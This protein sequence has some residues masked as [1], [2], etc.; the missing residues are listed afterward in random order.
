MNFNLGEGLFYYLLNTDIGMA[1]T[2]KYAVLAICFTLASI[3]VGYLLGSVNS[4]IVVSKLLYREDIRSHG[5][6]NAGLTNMLR[7]Y[8]K[9]AAGLT[10]LGD[11]LKTAIAVF[12]GGVLGGFWYIGGISLSGV[13][14]QLPLTYIAGFF[15]IV[16]HIWPVFYKFKGGKGV[17][18]TAVMALILTPIEFLILITVFIII[19]ALTKYVSLGSVT[20]GILYPI[21]VNGHVKVL[22]GI[23]NT[24]AGVVIMQDFIMALITILIA[25][26]IVY[27]H[28]ENLKRISEG[29][30]RKLSIG[31]KKKSDDN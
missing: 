16:G 10:L 23:M 15:S 3:A 9:G 28:R 18:C 6:G 17:L 2:V 25:I 5:S 31:G 30:E 7:T 24:D 29:T 20:V 13:E 1:D 8:G 19:V 26:L 21:V 11:F 27:C 22:M 12:I 4:A 14:T